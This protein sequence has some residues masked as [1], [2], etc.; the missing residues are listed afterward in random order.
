LFN[1]HYDER[2]FLP[3]HVYNTATSHPVAVILRS[4]KTPRG[5]GDPWPS[6]AP[7]PAHPP[8]LARHMHHHPE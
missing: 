7:D 8:A 3:V 1:A 2:C 6:A 5:Q 4:G